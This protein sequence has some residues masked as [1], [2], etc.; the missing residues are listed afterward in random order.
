MCLC[1]PLYKHCKTVQFDYAYKYN[2]LGT[3]LIW[4]KIILTA[5]RCHSLVNKLNLIIA[6]V[7]YAISNIPKTIIYMQQKANNYSSTFSRIIFGAYFKMVS[8]THGFLDGLKLFA[9]KTFKF[10]NEVLDLGLF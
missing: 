8:F 3:V 10:Q 5:L 1:I 4:G 6:E 9:Q 2:L 7:T